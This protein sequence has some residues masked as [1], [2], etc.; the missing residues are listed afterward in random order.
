[1]PGKKKK[2]FIKIKNIPFLLDLQMLIFSEML[3]QQ[4]HDYHSYSELHKLMQMSPFRLT[5]KYRNIVDNLTC[6]VSL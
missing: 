1:M 4:R 5:S 6:G 2:C 3:L